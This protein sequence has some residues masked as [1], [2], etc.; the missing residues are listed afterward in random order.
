MGFSIPVR[1]DR[2][3]G[4]GA[5]ILLEEELA[6]LPTTLWLF[7]HV[8]GVRFPI[9]RGL[10]LGIAI[11]G[12]ILL[13]VACVVV[14]LVVLQYLILFFFSLWRSGRR[15]FALPIF[16]VLAPFSAA[17]AVFGLVLETAVA[18]VV[19]VYEAYGTV[20]LYADAARRRL[21]QPLGAQL[22]EVW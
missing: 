17:L 21:L 11:T 6:D 3:G 15:A 1:I 20:A 19:R 7:A 8:D 18:C 4:D 13:Y 12:R 16:V 10:Q 9:L 14:Y 5:T 22:R 2:K